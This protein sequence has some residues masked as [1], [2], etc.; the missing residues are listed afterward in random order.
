M[1]LNFNEPNTY[2]EIFS[3]AILIFTI[4]LTE[5]LFSLFV[6]P[7]LQQNCFVQLKMFV[8]FLFCGG[9]LSVKTQNLT[10]ISLYIYIHY[11]CSIINDYF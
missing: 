3:F 8:S 9:F 4:I 2:Q 1:Y 10:K 7:T 6:S 5:K 11:S